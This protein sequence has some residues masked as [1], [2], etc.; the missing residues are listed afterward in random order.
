M[1]NIFKLYPAGIKIVADFV[2]KI[3]RNLNIESIEQD[4]LSAKYFSYPSDAEIEKFLNSK[5]SLI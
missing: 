1:T 2:Y 4:K 5:L 3:E